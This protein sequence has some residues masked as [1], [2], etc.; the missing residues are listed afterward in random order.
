MTLA[1]STIGAPSAAD[2]ITALEAAGIVQPTDYNNDF[3]AEFNKM[4]WLLLN[5]HSPAGVL[6]V[7]PPTATTINVRA[8]S[9]NYKGEAKTYTPTTDIDPTDNDTTYVWL[10]PDNTVDSGIDGDG[11]PATEH[12]K[13]AEVAV[14]ADGVI[15][16]ITDRRSE[17]MIQVPG[18]A[19]DTAT[20]ITRGDVRCQV[21]DSAHLE[22]LLDTVE[23]DL[24]PISKGDIIL[25]V[26]LFVATAAG[27]AC[28]VTI[29]TDVDVD[30]TTADPDALLKA[31]DAN[32]AGIY[33]SDNPALTY[34]GDD[35]KAGAFVADDDGYLTIT[36]ST[37]QSASSFV[38]QAVLMYIPKT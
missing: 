26:K 24:F 30:G 33:A 14:D 31:A 38:G 22:A 3:I 18:Q 34:Q 20:G 1:L 29:G 13:L 37:D 16:A 35:L 32:T 17:W 2:I 36:S 28:A 25:S 21:I 7:W 5:A 11:W 27:A 9:Y 8:G 6:G 19:A 12:A 23:N 10:D 15:T 4:L